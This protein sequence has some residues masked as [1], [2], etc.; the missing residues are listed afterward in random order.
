MSDPYLDLRNMA[1]GTTRASLE[2]AQPWPASEPWGVL[3]D[4]GYGDASVTVVAFADGNASVYLSNGG[5]FIGGF[6]HES[7]RSAA[8]AVVREAGRHLKALK[9]AT[10]HA[11]PG[12]GD[13]AFHVLTDAGVLTAVAPEQDLGEERHPLS[14]LFH[15]G[16]RVITEYRLIQEAG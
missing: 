4:I 16:Q 9:P 13:T 14:P 3:M 6:G 1:L 11:I 5:G 2:I 10:T 8:I 7:V 12:D 15:A